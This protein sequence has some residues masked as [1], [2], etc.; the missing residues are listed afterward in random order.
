MPPRPPNGLHACKYSIGT[1]VTNKICWWTGQ[2]LC[3]VNEDRYTWSNVYRAHKLLSPLQ[4]LPNQLHV[5]PLLLRVHNTCH[6]HPL[7]EWA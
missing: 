1:I 3:T 7:C 4:A 6:C 5:G 2:V